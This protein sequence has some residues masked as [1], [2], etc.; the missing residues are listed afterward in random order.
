MQSNRYPLQFYYKDRSTYPFNLHSHRECEIYYLHEGKGTFILGDTIHELQPGD[1]ILVSALTPHSSNA[2]YR[3]PY[4]RST[5]HFETG[6][7]KGL[8]HEPALRKGFM[9]FE[10]EENLT[11]R[12]NRRQRQELEA[13]FC[14]LHQHSLNKESSNRF[15]LHLLDLICF[16]SS[17]CHTSDRPHQSGRSDKAS[18]VGEIIAYLDDRFREDIELDQLARH[19]FMNKTYIA[20]IFKEVTGVTVFEY[21]KNKR[22][23]QAKIML[24]IN[25]TLSITEV[26]F[27]LGFK[28]SSHFSRTFKTYAGVTPEEY[29]RTMK[30]SQLPARVSLQPW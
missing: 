25:P 30:R 21:L 19:F 24:L 2:D 10:R 4:I 3:Y 9:P 13:I 16:V 17:L 22:I 29:R 11:L 14:E 23:N 7:M 20:K 28:H 15:L 26:C 8:V 6:Y 12:P 1:L 18:K 27:E 5:L